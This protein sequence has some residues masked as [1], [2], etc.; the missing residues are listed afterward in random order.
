MSRLSC[1]FVAFCVSDCPEI[2][3][4]QGGGASL[5]D[6]GD[7]R[8]VHW[9]EFPAGPEGRGHPL[10]VGFIY[11]YFFKL[12]P[13]SWYRIE[14]A[15]SHSKLPDLKLLPKL[16]RLDTSPFLATL[17]PCVGCVPAEVSQEWIKT[18][19]LPGKSAQARISSLFSPNKASSYNINM[20]AGLTV[21][22]ILQRLCVLLT[23]K[24]N[25]VFFFLF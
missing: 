6:W 13:L 3:P 14:N 18:V 16:P 21:T 20:A 12:L 24:V 25:E 2:R 9:R 11:F 15:P 8:V 10:R 23:F 5:L 17:L 1:K 4:A 7:D 22:L 19:L